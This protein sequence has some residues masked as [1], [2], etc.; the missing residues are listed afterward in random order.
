MNKEYPLVSRLV[1]LVKDHRKPSSSKST[2]VLLK[3]ME[4]Q[5]LNPGNHSVEIF[6]AELKKAL[7]SDVVWSRTITQQHSEEE[8]RTC[9]ANLLAG[10]ADA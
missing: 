3:V 8:L 2:G 6:K 1:V 5:I 10:L 7:A 9:F 4:A